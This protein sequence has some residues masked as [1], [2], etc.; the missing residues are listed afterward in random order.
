MF[1]IVLR[2]IEFFFKHQDFVINSFNL[3]L[4]ILLLICMFILYIKIFYHKTVP[5]SYLKKIYIYTFQ[6]ADC[7]IVDKIFKHKY[8]LI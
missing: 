2:H 5:P 4:Y 7:K 1:K 6:I 8:Q 3:N